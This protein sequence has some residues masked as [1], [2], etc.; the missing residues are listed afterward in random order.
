MSVKI[1]IDSTT[2]LIKEVKDKVE[3]VPLTLRFGE[4]EFIDGVTI[5]HKMFYESL[6]KAMLSRQQVRQPQ[7]LSSHIL[8]R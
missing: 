1:I 6:S 7:A 3:V 2:D 4:E 8:I 5:D